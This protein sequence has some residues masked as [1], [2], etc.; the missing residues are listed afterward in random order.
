MEEECQH[1][2]C[3]T[4]ESSKQCQYGDHGDKM[5][6]MMHI[7][8][9]AKMELLKEKVKRKLEAAEGKQL[10]EVADLIVEG[11]LGKYDLMKG[12]IK[13][14]KDMQERLEAI[15]AD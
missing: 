2:S 13:K 1:E 7:A 10:D 11:M 15:F 6:M 5:W 4:G 8:K 12:I 3:G 14:K 9:K